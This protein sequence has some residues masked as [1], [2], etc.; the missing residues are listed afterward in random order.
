[1]SDTINKRGK[2]L[3]DQFFAGREQAALEKLRNE[4]HEKAAVEAL[5]EFT[6][7]G[8]ESPEDLHF[9]E[10]LVKHGVNVATFGALRFTPVVLVAW[11]DSKL[12][13]AERKSILTKAS[14]MGVSDEV[15]SVL[16]NWLAAEPAADLKTAWF[17]FMGR[18]IGTLN[19][20]DK[21]ALKSEL[22][23]N[24]TDVAASAGG[25]FGF[26]T[27]SAVEQAVIDEVSSLF[28]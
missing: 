12:E 7:V 3:E 21:Q 9:V 25:Y 2:T 23:T 26:G 8:D 22:L 14:L 4:L 19:S 28:S 5:I 17:G 20:D 24:S 15:H 11:A 27:I 1:M 10:T 18:Y 13:D 6:G 16:D